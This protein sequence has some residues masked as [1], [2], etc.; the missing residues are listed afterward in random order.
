MWVPSHVGLAGNSAADTAAKAALLL[1]M[2]NLT[3]PHSDYCSL[4]RIHVL[5]QGQ[6][7][8][9]SE[10]QNK[11][12]IIEPKLNVIND[13]RPQRDEIIIH[14]L[15]IGHTYLMHGHLLRGKTTPRCSSCQVELKVEH[16]RLHCGCFIKALD[17]FFVV[18]VTTVAELFSKVSSRS[19]IDFIKEI[20]FY[21]KI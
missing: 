18:H 12:Q 2:S 10:T 13:Y 5:K 6:Q 9:D 7:S 3:V 15:T 17:D 19:I 21:R 4:K 16:I 1:P 8:W 20:G 14:R 11:L